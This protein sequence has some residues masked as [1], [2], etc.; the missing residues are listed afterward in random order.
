MCVKAGPVLRLVV[1]DW[2]KRDSAVAAMGPGLDFCQ[3]KGPI[4][5]APA[6]GRCRRP[7]PGWWA[8]Y[9]SHN[10]AVPLARVSVVDPVI[11][12]EAG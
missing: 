8:A 9:H 4:R 12:V 3:P 11:A 5:V 10:F 1:L 6:A 2:Q 7:G